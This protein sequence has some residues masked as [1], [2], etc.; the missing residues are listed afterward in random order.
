MTLKSNQLPG[1]ILTSPQSEHQQM[2]SAQTLRVSTGGT[3]KMDTIKAFVQANRHLQQM[4]YDEELRQQVE[5]NQCTIE[6]A[7]L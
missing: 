6:Q 3:S 1:A 4:Q 5:I 7:E 2:L